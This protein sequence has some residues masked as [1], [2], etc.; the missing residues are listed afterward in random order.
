MERHQAARVAL[1][2]LVVLLLVLLNGCATIPYDYTRTVSSAL[3]R[4]E[5]TSMGKKI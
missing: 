3:Y 5:G 4:P 1:R 2:H